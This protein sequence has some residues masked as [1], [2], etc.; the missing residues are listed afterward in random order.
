MTKAIAAIDLGTNTFNLL[1]A[2]PVSGGIG[3]ILFAEEIPVKLGEGGINQGYIAPEAYDRGLETMLRIRN[4]I[5]RHQPDLVLACATSAIRSAANGADFMASVLRE[6]GIAIQVID[7]NREAELIYLG[8]RA[9]LSLERRTLIMD[10]GGGSV[11]FILC[12]QVR[13]HWKKSY[14]IGAARLRERYHRTD[15]VSPETLTALHDHLEAELAD[16]LE[17]CKTFAPE[18]LVGSAG[19]FETYHSIISRGRLT[20]LVS[21]AAFDDAKLN[22]VL[23]ML[24]GSTREER[25]NMPGLAAFRV[26]MIVM[27]S[28]LTRFILQKTGISR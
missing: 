8:V 6:T 22:E 18:Q 15:P 1:I 23:T 5:D 24:V 2:E 16:L 20:A 12:D 25:E 14:P 13:I 11:E 3:R 19:A 27:A 9:A 10:I 7:G 26:D 4:V 17:T 28:A 21:A